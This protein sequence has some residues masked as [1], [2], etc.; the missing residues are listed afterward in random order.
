MG[1]GYQDVDAREI[2]D[3]VTDGLRRRLTALN[4]ALLQDAGTFEEL[5]E[6]VRPI[7]LG[8]LERTV[9]EDA[10]APQTF[11]SP[12]ADPLLSVEVR[13]GLAREGVHPVE[14]LR[15]AG[16]LF[17][18]AL[19]IITRHLGLQGDK[20]LQ[21]SQCL[22]QEIMDKA[23]LASLF[24]EEFLLTNMHSLV[25]K[26]RQ[27]ISRELHDR[28]GHGMALAVQHFD[29]YRYF[30]KTGDV[31]ADHEFATGLESLDEAFRTVRLLSTELRR[32]VGDDGISA[33]IDSYLRDNVP[34]GISASLQITGDVKI[35]PP[36]IG[37]ELYM[38]M[39]EACH[40]ALRHG[41]PSEIGLKLVITDSEVTAAISDNGRGFSV[42]APGNPAGG[43]LPSMTERAELLHG[44]L[45]VESTVG[46]GTT[47]TVRV[48][49]PNGV[50]A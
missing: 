6:R 11:S 42:A 7:I 30:R 5:T 21:V 49:L 34:V 27:R 45:R 22:H 17:D 4:S 13:T 31:R 26:E 38:I 1:D 15:A 12:A 8:V 16:E 9:P 14:S 44:V 36:L 39:R 46:E 10:Q 35:L 41:Q 19:P 25:D 23:A 20:I 18:V 2:I 29:M 33:A 43:G 3:E 28:V 37:E 48:P 47:V 24:Y 40:N 50:T 32:S